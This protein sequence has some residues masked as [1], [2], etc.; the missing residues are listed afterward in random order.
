MAGRDFCIHLRSCMNFLGFK[1][2]QGDREVWM[3]EAAKADGTQY[4]EYILLYVDNCLLVS[5]NGEKVLRNDIGKYFTLKETSIGPPKLY[6]GGEMSLVELANG[7]KAWAFRYS[8]YLQEAVQNFEYYLKEQDLNLPARAGA[9]F[10]PNYRPK[11]GETAELEP[12]DAAYYQS[13]IGI[14]W[15]IVELG[16]VDICTEVSLLS[17]CLAL[18]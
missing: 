10:S 7:A 18:T 6:L 8:Q 3:R 17:S 5:E 15:W 12:V 9:P 1:S 13:L 14:L 4:W 16:Q 2:S 11:I